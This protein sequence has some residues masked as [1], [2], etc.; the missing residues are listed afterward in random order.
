MK[1]L[2]VLSNENEPEVS[3]S[4]LDKEG[5]QKE[6]L[7]IELQDNGLHIYKRTMEDEDHYILP[8]IPEIDTLIKEIIEEVADELSV[9]TIIYKF[10][11]DNETEDLILSSIWHDLEKLA[12]AA[13]KHAAVSSE[14]ETKVVIGIVKFS[15]FIQA[16]TILRKEDSFPLMQ[17]FADF[18]TEPHSIKL[19]NEMGQLIENRKEKVEDFEEY[20][21]SLVNEEDFVVIYRESIGRSPSPIEVKYSNGA[22]LFVGVIF[23][24]IIGFNPDNASMPKIKNKRR[25]S[26]VIRGT[27]YVDRLSE[28]SGVD[29]VIGNPVTLDKLDTETQKIKKRI[30]RTLLKLGV[31]DPEIDYFGADQTVL[32]EIKESNPWMLL[33]PVGFL[34]LGSTKKEFEDFASR[35]V[36]GPTPDGMEILDE[37]IKKNL[38]NMFVGYLASLEEALILYSDIDEEVSKDE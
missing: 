3:C 34:I 25:L 7:H 5:Q 31:S 27:T 15:N 28:N 17:I 1:I 16:A 13:S 9:E 38:S 2:Q 14:V 8:P 19:Y 10:G 11:Q 29:V 32:R 20:V 36:M 24:Y 6:I 22:T 35:I 4:L 37:E 18:S 23:K 21:K 26:T 30:R 12:L 33:V